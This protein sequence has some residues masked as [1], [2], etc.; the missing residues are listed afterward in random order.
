M[1]AVIVGGIVPLIERQATLG[2]PLC[3][4]PGPIATM[5][6]TIAADSKWLSGHPPDLD[7][8]RAEVAMAAGVPL[9]EMQGV[10]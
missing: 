3:D 8:I 7:R 6:E 5:I 4:I 9:E 1:R 2:R 10:N